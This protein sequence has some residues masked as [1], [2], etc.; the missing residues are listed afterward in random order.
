[1]PK[2]KFKER[3]IN[4]SSRGKGAAIVFLHG[5]CED[6]SVWDD[7]ISVF[8][9]NK[10]IRIDLPGFGSSEPIDHPSVELFADVVKSVLNHLEIRKC[11]LIGHSMGGYVSLAFAKKYASSLS[12]LGIFHSF[13]YADSKEKKAGRA[14][15]IEF[16]KKNSHFHYVKQLFPNLF[17]PA[18]LSSNNFLVNKM[19]HRASSFPQAGIIGGLELMMNRPDNSEILKNI[20][21]PVLFII[22]RD[23]K[24][25]PFDKSMEQT[26]LPDI[27]HI[28]VLEG[29][30]HMG[31]FEAT[32][33]TRKIIKQFLKHCNDFSKTEISKKIN[34]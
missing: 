10:I 20:K 16:I 24:V 6:S 25:I 22:G 34:I 7:F 26:A 17:P 15:S 3:K 32:K 27:A 8:K 31:M 14:K 13:P 9:S 18:F 19:I 33:D 28:H 21:C 30:G 5:F 1:M 2:I 4:Y 12:G 11:H 23:D 29:V